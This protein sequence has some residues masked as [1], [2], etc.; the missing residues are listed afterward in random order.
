MDETT[1]NKRNIQAVLDW[2]AQHRPD[3]GAVVEAE[4]SNTAFVLLLEI[5]FEAGRQFQH[6]NPTEALYPTHSYETSI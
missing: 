5:G 1:K 3:L 6:T 2:C 4:K